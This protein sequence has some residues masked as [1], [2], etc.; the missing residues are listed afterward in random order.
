MQCTAG[1]RW[2]PMRCTHPRTPQLQRCLPLWRNHAQRLN[3]NPA[4][5]EQS[6]H[7][8]LTHACLNTK[9]VDNVDITMQMGLGRKI[10]TARATPTHPMA[11]PCVS[12]NVHNINDANGTYCKKPSPCRLRFHHRCPSK[13]STHKR[14]YD[15]NRLQTYHPKL[16]ST[17]RADPPTDPNRKDNHRNPH[18]VKNPCADTHCLGPFPCQLL[19][20]Q[21]LFHCARLFA[22]SGRGVRWVNWPPC[23]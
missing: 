22:L 8:Q 16:K 2:P 14:N 1:P 21:L 4:H 19:F 11:R 13:M 23:I 12:W 10:A 6:S 20:C 5:W 17:E 15:L 18:P 7:T 9:D 3:Q